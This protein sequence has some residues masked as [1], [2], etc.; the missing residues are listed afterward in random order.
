MRYD[1]FTLSLLGML[2]ISG[3]I[4]VEAGVS[5]AVLTFGIYI[6]LAG[7]IRALVDHVENS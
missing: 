2:M 7:L 4:F 3:V 1:G 6:A 5:W